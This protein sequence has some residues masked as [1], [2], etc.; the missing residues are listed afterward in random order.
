MIVVIPKPKPGVSM[1]TGD[2]QELQEDFTNEDLENPNFLHTD[3][4]F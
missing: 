3:T 4:A 2:G 1:G